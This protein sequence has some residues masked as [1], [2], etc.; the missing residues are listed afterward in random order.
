MANQTGVHGSVYRNDDYVA[1]NRVS[2]GAILAGTIVALAVQI[3][4]TLLGFSIGLGVMSQATDTSALG[5]VGIG[6][7]IWLVVSTLISLYI[8][9]YV[10]ARLAGVPTKTD[11]VLNGVVVWAL[12]TLLSL[13]LAT[14]AVGTAVSGVAGIIGQGLQTATSGATTVA[15]EAAEALKRNPQ[16]A[17]ETARQAVDE[18]Q[19]QYR[20]VRRQAG[21]TLNE[22]QQEAA[23]TARQAAPVAS[24]A[25][26]G[27]FIALVLGA[28]AAALGGMAGIPKDVVASTATRR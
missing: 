28:F 17:R 26:F 14:S 20:Q 6:G 4:L 13:Y 1:V 19:Q 5:G 24:G 16:E 9:G 8:G 27:G 22:A 3:V 11:G 2:W 7:M 18:V 15:P 25:A 12:A 10:A 21:Q 23:Q